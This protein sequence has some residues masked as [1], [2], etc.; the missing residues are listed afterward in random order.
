M[1]L[2]AA[3][4]NVQELYSPEAAKSQFGGN[5]GIGMTAPQSTLQVR[6]Y[7]Q[8]DLTS[9]APPAGDCDPAAERGRRKVDN[10][11]GLLWIC[12]DSRWASK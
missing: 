4:A 6:G 7:V 11:T 8:L 5:V 10:A 12:V 2:S 9:G 1:Q 3:D